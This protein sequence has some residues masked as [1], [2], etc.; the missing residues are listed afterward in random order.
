MYLSIPFTLTVDG[1][2]KAIALNLPLPAL[3]PLKI[4]SGYPSELISPHVVCPFSKGFTV[5]LDC[6]NWIVLAAE[7][8]HLFW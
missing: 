7:S 2:A 3:L 1:S 4:M 6:T 5:E 8:N